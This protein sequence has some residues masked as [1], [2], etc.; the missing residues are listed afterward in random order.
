MAWNNHP[1]AL[2]EKI[3][4]IE[5]SLRL[6][7]L[8]LVARARI[9]QAGFAERVGVEWRW[10]QWRKETTRDKIGKVVAM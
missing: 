6:L 1:K 3:K 4:H 7:L 9:A 8:A 10:S 2:M 5:F